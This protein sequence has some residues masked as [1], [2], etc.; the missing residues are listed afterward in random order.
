[1]RFTG[2]EF[3]RPAGPWLALDM[4]INRFECCQQNEPPTRE[5]RWRL[6]CVARSLRPRPIHVKPYLYHVATSTVDTSFVQ[7]EAGLV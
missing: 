1:M 2:R 3:K 6:T 7:A 4:A 5:D